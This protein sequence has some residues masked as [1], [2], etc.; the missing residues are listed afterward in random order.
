MNEWRAANTTRHRQAVASGTIHIDPAIEHVRPL[1]AVDHGRQVVGD[2]EGFWLSYQPEA[3]SSRWV[4][5]NVSNVT[6]TSCGGIE[7][8]PTVGGDK[9]GARQ[10]RMAGVWS[11]LR[12][13]GS[14]LGQQD[15]A[16]MVGEQ[17]Q[18]CGVLVRG[19]CSLL[20]TGSRFHWSSTR[21]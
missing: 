10:W 4:G 18:G 9:Y 16:G 5:C 11:R 17:V 13:H 1:G 19:W 2:G 14:D 3:P 12:G 8:S 6:E 7:V 15:T 20:V 21:T